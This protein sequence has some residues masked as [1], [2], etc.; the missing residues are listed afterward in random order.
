MPTPT[1]LLRPRTWTVLERILQNIPTH[2]RLMVTLRLEIAGLDRLS[3]NCISITMAFGNTDTQVFSKD[4]S[5]DSVSCL[6]STG[7]HSSLLCI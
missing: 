6:G 4:R 1:N 3:P 2:H 7:T 5:V